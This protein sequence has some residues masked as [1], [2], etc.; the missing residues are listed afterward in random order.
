MLAFMAAGGALA[1]AGIWLILRESAAGGA[2]KIAIGPVEMQSASVGFTVFLAGATSFTAPLVAP[3][4]TEELFERAA[5][6]TRGGLADLGPTRRDTATGL[7]D[8]VMP[9]DPEPAN[10]TIE[11]AT[12]V[13]VGDL[14]GGFHDG[15]N[16][17][18]FQLDTGE[19]VNRRIAVE[20]SEKIEDCYA[21]FYDGQQAY[22]GLV[23]LIPGRNQFDL[24]VNDNASFYLQLSCMKESAADAYTIIF[25]ARLQKPDTGQP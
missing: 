20:I 25:D 16:S 8:G 23:S 9:A 2:A 13:R 3:E 11:G 18:W 7:P 12:L 17:D 24:D 10:D 14:A 6:A 1:A 22:L 15:Q 19:L 5:V 4:A 21:H